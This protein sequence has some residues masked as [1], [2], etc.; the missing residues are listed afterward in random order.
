MVARK[1]FIKRIQD[2][3]ILLRR[4]P[5]G[6]RYYRHRPIEGWSALLIMWLRTIGG[7]TMDLAIL[8]I[9]GRKCCY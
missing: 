2:E 7:L 1:L 4:W 8:L 3:P 9:K 6:R 5:Y